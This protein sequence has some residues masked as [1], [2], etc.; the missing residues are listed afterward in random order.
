MRHTQFIF[1]WVHA[2]LNIGFVQKT[3]VNDEMYNPEK[4]VA[5]VTG[6]ESYKNVR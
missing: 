6:D 1:R 5:Y 3:L 2:T 4:N